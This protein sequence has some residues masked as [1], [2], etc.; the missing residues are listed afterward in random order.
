MSGKIEGIQV[1]RA[2]AAIGV[3]LSHSALIVNAIPDSKKIIIPFIYSYGGMGV[4][5]FFVISGFIIA[6]VLDAKR[7]DT[8]SFF[9]KRIFRIY[10]AYWLV[11]FAAIYLHQTWQISFHRIYPHPDFILKSL[12][13]WP[14]P[15]APFFQVGWTL[16][17]E[18]IFYLIAGLLVPLAGLYAVMVAFTVLG[19]AGMIGVAFIPGFWGYNVVSE[20]NLYFAAGMAIY[21]FQNSLEKIHWGA[22]A[23]GSVVVLVLYVALRPYT[24]GSTFVLFQVPSL[25]IVFLLLCVSLMN[26]PAQKG[27][28]WRILVWCG[29]IS[30]SL[31]LTHWIVYRVIRQWQ[32][33]PFIA[34]NPELLRWAGIAASFLL[35][36]VMYKFVEQPSISIGHYL[37]AKARTDKR[38]AALP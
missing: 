14:I 33:Q 8:R 16:E 18:I 25:I 19:V 5:L 30:Y 31:Y 7:D 23:L 29:N 21:V 34:D 6:K 17:H 20:M 32:S 2:L 11:T 24:A 27:V 22:A 12:T 15:A 26:M 10:P 1:A 38:E 36:W 37:A 9:I 13:L 35:A 4:Q 3:M 28:I